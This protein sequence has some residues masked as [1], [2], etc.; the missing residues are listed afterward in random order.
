MLCRNCVIATTL[1]MLLLSGCNGPTEQ[2]LKVRAEA[3]DRMNVARTNITY[4]QAQQAFEEGKFEIAL[5][6]I[7]KAI[8]QYSTASHFH[9]LRGRIFLETHRLEGALHAFLDAIEQD[10]NNHKAY[11][12]QGIV[13]QRWSDDEQAYEKYFAAWE[14]DRGNVHYILAAAESLIALGEYEQAKSLIDERIARF[15]YNSAMKHL[16]GELAMLQGRPGDAVTRYTE[17]RL[18]DP[19]NLQL[20]ED[21]AWAQFSAGRFAECHEALRFVQGRLPAQR[22]DLMRLDAQCLAMIG[23]SIEARD[24]YVKLSRAMATDADVWIELGTIAWEVG[25]YIRV[26]E[27]ASR[28]MSLAPSRYEGYLLQAMFEK[29]AGHDEL[30]I[31]QLR[32]AVA[33]ATDLASPHLLLGRELEEAGRGAEALVVYRQALTA[34]PQSVEAQIMHDR[35]EQQLRLTSASSAP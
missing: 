28:S 5:R 24:L 33:R 31:R 17:A 19:E 18:L 9:V 20:M 27:C 29:H 11:Y 4:E 25:D 1:A 21:L 34:D 8:A 15:E 30:V 23:R 6:E 7:E 26:Q 2:G 10:E 32:N 3:H 16:Q 14:L 35:L 12:Y 13:F 22:L